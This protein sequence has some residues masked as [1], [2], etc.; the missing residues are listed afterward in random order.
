MAVSAT[1]TY[2][3]GKTLILVVLLD[4]AEFA[5]SF[6]LFD[7]YLSFLFHNLGAGTLGALLEDE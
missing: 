7:S 5:Y 3:E 2:D 1:H 4:L 6:V